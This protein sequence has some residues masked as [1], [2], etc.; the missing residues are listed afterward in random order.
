MY[1]ESWEY[2]WIKQFEG[3]CRNK[4]AVKHEPTENRFQK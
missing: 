1:Y 2:Y 3:W 4:Q